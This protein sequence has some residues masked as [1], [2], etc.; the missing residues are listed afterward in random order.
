MQHP[1][2]T[3]MIHESMQRV[4]EERA[5]LPRVHDQL[6][7]ISTLRALMGNCLIGLGTRIK[8]ATRPSAVASTMAGLPL[9][10]PSRTRA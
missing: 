9:T 5:A 3:M 2:L 7:P 1:D 8:P 4:T 6:G 10:T